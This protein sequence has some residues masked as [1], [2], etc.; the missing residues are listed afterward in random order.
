MNSHKV[1][2]ALF[3]HLCLTASG[4]WKNG[5]Y[6]G[7]KIILIMNIHGTLAKSPQLS[8]ELNVSSPITTGQ[9]TDKNDMLMQEA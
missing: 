8:V 5:R 4:L 2:K 9:S 1:Q 7:R 3:I 6:C